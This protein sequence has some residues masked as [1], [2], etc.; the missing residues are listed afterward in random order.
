[1]FFLNYLAGELST[2]NV[3]PVLPR[4][5]HL[6]ETGTSSA[7]NSPVRPDM[8]DLASMLDDL[9]NDKRRFGVFAIVIATRCGR[10]CAPTIPIR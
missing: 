5:L 4:C 10:S 6:I 3:T 9:T 7:G 2:V 1:M 8:N